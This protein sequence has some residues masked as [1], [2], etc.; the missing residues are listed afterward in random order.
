MSIFIANLGFIAEPVTLVA[1][2][3]AILLASLLAGITGFLW[4]RFLG[5]A[6]GET[7]VETRPRH[8]RPPP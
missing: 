7:A 1:A 4:L 8:P 2:K 6:P 3:T 5:H